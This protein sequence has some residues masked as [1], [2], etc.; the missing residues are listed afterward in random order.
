MKPSFKG[1]N[2]SIIPM[3]FLS[4]FSINYLVSTSQYVVLNKYIFDVGCVGIQTL[5]T[6]KF[7]YAKHVKNTKLWVLKMCGYFNV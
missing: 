7:R 2:Y 1:N 3:P 4:W 6:G 5:G